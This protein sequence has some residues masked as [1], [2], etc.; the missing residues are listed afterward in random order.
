MQT[1]QINKIKGLINISNKAGYLIIGSDILKNYN[2]KLYLILYSNNGG[3]NLQK[4]VTRLKNS[5]TCESVEIDSEEFSKIVT[6]P[7]CKIVGLKNLGLSK[8][9]IK[10]IRGE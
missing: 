10:I 3:K 5:T 8:E 1:Q 9:I 7:N 4:I 6:I 2:K